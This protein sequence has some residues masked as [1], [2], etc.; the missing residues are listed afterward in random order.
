MAY[1]IELHSKY[2]NDPLLVNIEAIGY[3]EC[4]QDGA[5]LIHMC[6]TRINSSSSGQ[7]LNRVDGSM[8]IIYVKESYQ[9]IKSKL[10]NY[11]DRF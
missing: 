5:A 9:E 3:V 8:Q 7:S 11:Y 4:G 1:F 6:G 2:D 10:S